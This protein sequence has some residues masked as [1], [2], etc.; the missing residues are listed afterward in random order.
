M[1]KSLQA[2]IRSH[3][4]ECV[5]KLY[6]CYIFTDAVKSSAVMDQLCIDDDKLTACWINYLIAVG[7]IAHEHEILYESVCGQIAKYASAVHV[8]DPDNKHVGLMTVIDV[9]DEI[10]RDSLY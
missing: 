4:D 1:E 6:D 3:I 9:I 10:I 5:F 8:V 2:A 7:L